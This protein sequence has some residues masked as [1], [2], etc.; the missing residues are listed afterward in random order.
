MTSPAPTIPTIDARTAS[1]E[2]AAESDPRP[3]LVDVRNPDE[4]AEARIAE[5]VLIPLPVFGERFA[6]LPTDRPLFL[7]CRSGARSAAATAHLVRNGYQSASNVRGG[8]EAWMAAGL[9]VRTGPP[10]PGEGDLG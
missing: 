9:P 8:I 2:L 3:L 6:E 1:D 5:S 10:E 4:F 7:L